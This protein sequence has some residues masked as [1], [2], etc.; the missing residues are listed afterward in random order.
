DNRTRFQS[1][2]LKI[3]IRITYLGQRLYRVEHDIAPFLKIFNVVALQGVLELRVA[4]PAS[5]ANLLTGLQEKR[6]A[7]QLQPG[8]KA[9]NHL[10][11]GNTALFQRLQLNV[12]LSE[13]SGTTNRTAYVLHCGIGHHNLHELAKA[14]TCNS[15]RLIGRRL[16]ASL[17][18]PCVLLGEKAF[19]Y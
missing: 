15:K 5:N 3:C 18:Q 6:R 1:L 7:R 10:V 16:N 13:S 8:T 12:Y 11:G 17:Q 19:G 4:A 9:C 2:V 14:L